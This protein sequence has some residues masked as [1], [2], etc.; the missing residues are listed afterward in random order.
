MWARKIMFL[1]YTCHYLFYNLDKYRFCYT[2]K[3]DFQNSSPVLIQYIHPLHLISPC[4]RVI[5]VPFYVLGN[6]T[7]FV[8]LCKTNTPKENPKLKSYI[9]CVQTD[10][11]CLFKTLNIFLHM[12]PKK[13]KTQIKDRKFIH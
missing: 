10:K 9:I 11:V 6:I 2:T 13:L 5:R 4:S 12:H 7:N 8:N 3:T 1:Q